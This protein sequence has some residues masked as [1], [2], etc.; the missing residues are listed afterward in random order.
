M[1][2]D[3]LGNTKKEEKSEIFWESTEIAERGKRG[4]RMV[5]GENVPRWGP[6]SICDHDNIDN[7]DIPSYGVMVEAIFTSSSGGCSPISYSTDGMPSDLQNNKQRE[8]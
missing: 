8:E 1:F 7:V 4:H 5:S 3:I 6:G 2:D